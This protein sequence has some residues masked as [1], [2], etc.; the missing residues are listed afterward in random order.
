MKLRNILNLRI[1]GTTAVRLA[2][3]Y[4]LLYSLVLGLAILL[5]RWSA[6]SSVN[7]QVSARLEHELFEIVSA[8]NAGDTQCIKDTFKDED[9]EL[10]Y[11][12][13]SPEDKRLAGNLSEWPDNTP[14][15]GDEKVHPVWFEEEMLP[16]K[17]F[18]NDAYVPVLVHRFP[19]GNTLVLGLVVKQMN[20][21]KEIAEFLL[22]GLG[23]AV[24]LAFAIGIS[25]GKSVLGRMD[26]ISR[27]A[28]EIA[29]GNLSGR[30]PVSK[31]GD[32]FDVLGMQLNTMLGRIQLLLR[33]MREVTDNIAHDLRSPLTRLR[34]QLEVTLLAD[35]TG[36]EYREVIHRGVEDV[37]SLI[38][39]FQA[40]LGIAQAEA[41]NLRSEW[42]VVRLDAIA[43]D[44][45]DL[46]RPVAED[47]EQNLVFKPAAGDN[48]TS[49]VVGSRELLA[50][51]LSNLLEN[52]LKF[53]PAG[54]SIHVTV[55]HANNST[56]L[57]VSD[58]GPG[59]PEAEREH[60][61]ERFVRLDN[62]RH[63]PGNGLGL[64]LVK[65]VSNLHHA[66]LILGNA[67]PGLIVTIRFSPT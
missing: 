22:Q 11:L 33:Q 37:S 5:L 42:G 38:R 64:S 26:S 53:T 17:L 55:S 50:E 40:L 57:T 4:V 39:T 9:K 18:Q 67:G 21:L 43:A 46:Y 7:P 25:V 58:T 61:L 12:L 24:L 45:V 62:A 31:R 6:S 28:S 2:F 27:T 59:I 14:V 56:E 66:S 54:G 60:V 30:I 13:L 3:R 44:V 52:A 65:A 1:L 23:L 8:C 51:A 36:E 29:A 16:R 34:S 41:G 20:T 32:E 19:N 47:R 10:V 49:E 48:S 15:P 35:R 63:T